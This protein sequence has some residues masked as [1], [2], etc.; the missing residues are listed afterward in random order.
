MP[1]NQSPRF[2]QESKATTV[3]LNI[4]LQDVPK[5]R[6][7]ISAY[8]MDK[9]LPPELAALLLAIDSKLPKEKSD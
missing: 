9:S 7:L 4:P 5:L 8:T 3:V 6:V 2:K 1:F